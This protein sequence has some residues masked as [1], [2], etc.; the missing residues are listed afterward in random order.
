L[1]GVAK[2]PTVGSE[3]EVTVMIVKKNQCIRLLIVPAGLNN[4][5]E[6]SITLNSRVIAGAGICSELVLTDPNINKFSSHC[7]G[8]KQ[9]SL[10]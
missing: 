8:Q 3:T 10:L 9:P 7:A 2:L 5:S 4:Y 6:A 1:I